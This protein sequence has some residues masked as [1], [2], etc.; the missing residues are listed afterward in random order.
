MTEPIDFDGCSRACRKQAA[1]TLAWP[2]CAEAP[3]SARPEPVIHIGPRFF[4]APDGE[5]GI[6]FDTFTAAQLTERIE[7]ALRSVSITL[8][9][10][11]RAMLERGEAVHLSG[12]EYWSMA[13]AAAMDLMNPEEDRMATPID[14]TAAEAEVDRYR[15]SALNILL[16]APSWMV[17]PGRK[18][19]HGLERTAREA[20]VA[21]AAVAA[22]ETARTVVRAKIGGLLP[23]QLGL[24]L[25]DEIAD[26]VH[27]ALF[28]AAPEKSSS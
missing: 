11:A 18:V 16:G 26:A 24:D 3:E 21:Q 1:H 13:H 27:A 19:I 10:N 20:A 22:R 8:G 7:R 9:P 23:G 14:P 17:D 6:G 12:G 28:P 4:T 2:E 25:A 5:P 15:Q